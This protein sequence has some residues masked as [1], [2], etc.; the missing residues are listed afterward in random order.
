MGLTTVTYSRTI[1]LDVAK[2]KYG[3][4]EDNL[5]ARVGF[6]PTDG[7]FADLSLRPLGYR[8]ENFKYSETG[9]NLSVAAHCENSS[10]IRL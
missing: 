3:G 5:E 7:G 6:E 8:A 4:R 10:I 9:C 1:I 2:S